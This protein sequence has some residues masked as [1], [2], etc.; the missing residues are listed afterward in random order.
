MKEAKIK[1]NFILVAVLFTFLA[2]AAGAVLMKVAMTQYSEVLTSLLGEDP[3]ASQMNT[4]FLIGVAVLAVL[5]ILSAVAAAVIGGKLERALAGAS[6]KKIEATAEDEAARA[7]GEVAN[8]LQ[9]LADGNLAVEAGALG[10]YSESLRP[11]MEAVNN[12]KT[13]LS[14]SLSTIREAT[15][16]IATNAEQ[17]SNSAQALAQGS[18][19]Q[20][21]SV[22]ALSSIVTEMRETSD[23]T[24][25]LARESSEL[26]RQADS[27]VDDCGANMDDMVTAMEE[28]KSSSEEVREIID[29]IKNIAFQT[30]I[31]ALNA[32]VEAA[33]AGTAGK[34]FAVVADEVRNLASKSDEAARATETR[35]ENAIAA[36]RKGS[37]HVRDV[38]EALSKV[39]ELVGDSMSKMETVA[40]S[41]ERQAQNIAQINEGIEQ[42]SAVVQA[43]TATSEETAAASE[44]LNYQSHTMN[45]FMAK[46]RLNE[47]KEQAAEQKT[48]RRVPRTR[49]EPAKPAEPEAPR[50]IVRTKIEPEAKPFDA[51]QASARPPEPADNK[52]FVPDYDDKY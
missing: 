23:R 30:N 16:K 10:G 31:L 9:E 34:G 42:I 27:Q 25:Q 39:A 49:T 40:S 37:G 8:I 36:V 29:T 47:T 17:V 24:A 46:F 28:I 20:A 15:N 32:A 5:V 43:N 1:K 52:V 6:E 41:D 44:E 12:I 21:I 51:R 2:A 7:F 35:I 11:L 3:A 22:D 19:E 26:S 14:G 50:K 18:T 38:S 13:S 4:L 33:R 48:A 45:E